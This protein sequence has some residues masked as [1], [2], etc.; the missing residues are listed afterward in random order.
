MYSTVKTGV[1]FSWGCLLA[2]LFLGRCLNVIMVYLFLTVKYWVGLSLE[3]NAS[4]AL[5]HLHSSY[6][7]KNQERSVCISL[8]VH[9]WDRLSSSFNSVELLWAD[10]I[11]DV[12]HISFYDTNGSHE[13]IWALLLRVVI[14]KFNK[15]HSKVPLN[16]KHFL[17]LLQYS[18]KMIN[19]LNLWLLWT[20]PS[21]WKVCLKQHWSLTF[22]NSMSYLLSGR[23]RSRSTALRLK[24]F[25]TWNTAAWSCLFDETHAGF[26]AK[27]VKMRSI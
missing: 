5:S 22:L 7:E 1:L 24:Q 13:T 19:D 9:M 16:S 10:F 21:L 15:S 14:K 6:L 26:S 11:Y 27:W 3:E 12:Y 17:L 18:H 25:K 23:F 20:P 2:S 8:L 4:V